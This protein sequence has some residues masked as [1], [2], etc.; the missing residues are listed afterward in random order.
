MVTID[1]R[2]PEIGGFEIISEF[3]LAVSQHYGERTL[4]R[5]HGDRDWHPV[6]SV[7]R[8]NAYGITKQ[9]HLSRW[10]SVAQRFVS[11]K[12]SDDV[13]YLALAQHYG[14]STG[15]LDWTSNPLTALFF[16]CINSDK[17]T[18]RVLQVSRKL[19]NETE[20]TMM[21]EPFAESRPQPL[22]FDTSAMNVRS[23]AQDS[24]MSLH[25]QTEPE[26]ETT[27]IFEVAHDDKFKVR[28]GLALLGLT[29]E[30][31]YVDLSV[32]ADRFKEDL[33]L[34]WFLG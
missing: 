30:R 27:A 32:A 3:M 29:P 6:A 2:F 16:A 23:T 33:N 22:L 26:I 25:T 18:G 8:D 19:F 11:P 34:E 5:G 12:P 1:L 15:L 4:Y 17:A 24:F 31:V 28:A 10:K 13:G 21:V 9:D 20:Y 14:V 7:Y